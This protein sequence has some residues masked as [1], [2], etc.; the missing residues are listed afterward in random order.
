MPPRTGWCLPAPFT[1]GTVISE[2]GT[3]GTALPTRRAY[4]TPVWGP[5]ASSNGM[6]FAS[7]LH[8]RHSDFR[9]WDMWY[10]ATDKEGIRDTSMG[11]ICLLERDGVCQH[12]SQQAQ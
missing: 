8:N 11:T 4:E 1:T 12:P 2:P 6:V 7:T 9:T 10:S 3:C 5:Y